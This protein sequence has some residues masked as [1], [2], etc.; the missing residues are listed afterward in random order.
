MQRVV[1]E[2]LEFHRSAVREGIFSNQSHIIAA[3]IVIISFGV[4][5]R[6]RDPHM[7]WR[8]LS[9]FKLGVILVIHLH[10]LKARPVWLIKNKLPIELEFTRRVI[11]A[12]HAGE[13]ILLEISNAGLGVSTDWHHPA[14]NRT[15]ATRLAR[16]TT[17]LHISGYADRVSKNFCC[18]FGVVCQ[19]RLWALS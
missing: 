3:K 9:A 2:M 10:G 14:R 8:I 16:Q 6:V 15:T 4:I 12:V 17:L 11:I 1:F 5:L 13:G 18:P 19:I 7:R